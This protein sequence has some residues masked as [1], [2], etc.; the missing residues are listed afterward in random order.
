MDLFVSNDILKWK[1]TAFT[2]ACNESME[3]HKCYS[4]LEHSE[5]LLSISDGKHFNADVISNLKKAIDHRI[6]HL[7][8]QFKLKSL[9]KIFGIP[10]TYE[11]LAALKVI[12]P[13]MLAKLLDVRNSLEHQ[14]SEPP[15]TERCAEYLEFV[16]YFLK[17]TDSLAKEVRF[18]VSLEHHELEHLWLTFDVNP[19]T[20]WNVMVS[21][22]IPEQNVFESANSDTFKIIASE[23]R[24]G[25]DK[26]KALE[27][28]QP[29]PLWKGLSKNDF[30]ISNAKVPQSKFTKSLIQN[31]FSG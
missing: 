6:K 26:L 10:T 24:R 14:F 9:G 7:A 5:K 8:K 19:D 15:K 12:R 27:K 2:Y 4:Y 25:S 20:D 11:L 31:Y 29:D 21:G 1:A 17:S 18:D 22:W 3:W 30:W 23:Y 28:E 16:W 13:I